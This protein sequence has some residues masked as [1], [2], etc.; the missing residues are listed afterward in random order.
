MKKKVFK[1]GSAIVLGFALSSCNGGYSSN[2]VPPLHYDVARVSKLDTANDRI[3][4]RKTRKRGA[5]SYIENAL[6]KDSTLKK[7]KKGDLVLYGL[8]SMNKVDTLRKII[9]H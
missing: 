3:Y 7:L 5:D 1:L 4:L 9:V 6:G 8:D 2:S